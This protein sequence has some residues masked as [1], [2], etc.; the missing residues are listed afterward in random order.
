MHASERNRL[1][2]L[3]RVL[4]L[5]ASD[6]EQAAAAARALEKETD[7][8]LSRALE[9]AMAICYMRPFT[10]SSL[11]R[12]PVE[13]VPNAQ[14]DS[15]FHEGLSELRD[16]VYAHTDKASG[17]RASLTT[18]V[19]EEIEGEGR[20][21]AFD[22]REEWRAFPRQEIPSLLNFFER[23]RW[24]FAGAAMDI[25]DELEEAGRL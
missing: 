6:M 15:E 11:L 25:H 16:T 20:I 18:R 14:P 4:L 17:R 13:Y 2:K 9:T 12:L 10:K 7:G 5:A 22:S 8:T 24:A 23:R 19:V 21:L 1:L 3:Q